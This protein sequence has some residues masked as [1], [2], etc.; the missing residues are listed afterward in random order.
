MKIK[1]N[2]V[3]DTFDLGKKV[4]INIFPGAVICL[5]GDLGS[6][7]THFVKG[8]ADALLI[9][10]EIT[11][12]TFNIVNVYDSQKLDLNHFDIYRVNDPEEIALI[13]FDDYIFGNNVSVIE[14]ADLIEDLIP[15]DALWIYI[16]KCVNNENCREFEFVTKSDK[17]KYLKE[18]NE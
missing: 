11:S 17:F 10:D 13:G 12:P 5:V 1:S 2:S 18:V 9:K 4:G 6:G 14:W 3:N 7:K 16:S 15:K 8:L